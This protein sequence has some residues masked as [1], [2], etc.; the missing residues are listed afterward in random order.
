MYTMCYTL[1]IESYICLSDGL[2]IGWGYVICHFEYIN[3]D[4]KE[5][6]LRA[7]VE[8]GS[9]MFLEWTLRVIEMRKEKII[10]NN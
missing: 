7:S 6:G 3:F 4:L 9:K 2:I 5:L 8:N 10:W 1:S